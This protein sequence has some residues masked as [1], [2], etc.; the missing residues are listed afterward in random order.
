MTA[1]QQ[2]QHAIQQA[3][4]IREQRHTIKQDLQAGTLTLTD[5][6]TAPHPA[7]AT[8]PLLDVMLWARKRGM[9]APGL[10]RVGEQAI[11]DRVNLLLPVG[12][13]SLRMRKWCA[14]NTPPRE[15]AANTSHRKKASR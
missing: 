14:E 1:T 5:I 15:R 4:R 3:N 2:R 8:T 6:L 9:Q 7:V 12:S 10:A 13:A 11:R